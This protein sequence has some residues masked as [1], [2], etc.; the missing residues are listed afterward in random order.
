MTP[1]AVAAIAPA[2][3]KA[4][5]RAGI[6][7]ALQDEATREEVQTIFRD[8]RAQDEVILEPTIEAALRRLRE[9]ARPRLLIVDLSASTAPI[10]VLT[11]ARSIGGDELKILALGTINDVGLYRDLVAA[12]ASDYL[13]K[14]VSRDAL[15][16][17]WEGIGNPSAGGSGA[18]L[19]RVI[20]FVGSRGGVGTTTT[21]V[22]CA[23]L[24]ADRRKE[25][26]VLV[27]LNLHFGTVALYLD[28][29]PGGG[30]CEALEKPARIDSLFVDRAS[31]K[32][33][34]TLRI[35]A[36][37]VAVADT[38]AIDAGA[39]DVL[40]YELRRKFAW[41]VIDLPRW[42]SPPHRVAIEAASRVVIVCERSLAGLR[43][44]I[45][46]QT[47]I[48]E[49]APQTRVLLVESGASGER[50]TVGR[51]EFEKAVGLPLDASLSRDTRSACAAT[52]AGQPLPVAAP[53]SPVVRDLERLIGALGGAAET[54]R[55][56]FGL[57]LR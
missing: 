38:L 26:T 55:K 18:G 20:A 40:M 14:P 34:D 13:V 6:I 27:D 28:S 52:S 19:G 15:A 31:V 22:A 4:P 33:S 5:D 10:A 56:L 25:S 43:D 57:P 35:L 8:L 50:A 9:G 24:L 49:H 39:I 54:K 48:R 29:E 32:I 16:T 44:T 53:R 7:V 30:L 1:A 42:L 41:V 23:W 51:A 17:L 45:R 21:A 36:A 3:K 11:A 37:E 2:A 47:L 46:L 12:G